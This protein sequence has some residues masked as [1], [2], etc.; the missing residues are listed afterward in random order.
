MTIQFTS[1][2]FNCQLGS[3][4]LLGNAACRRE[5]KESRTYVIL[6]R[7]GSPRCL[8]QE[9]QPQPQPEVLC[10]ALHLQLTNPQKR[11]QIHGCALASCWLPFP[12]AKRRKRLYIKKSFI[13]HGINYEGIEG[14][15]I[16]GQIVLRVLI[17]S[18]FPYSLFTRFYALKVHDVIPR[19]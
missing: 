15:S 5:V 11:Q 10:F 6:E 8:K 18:K 12:H 19:S 9:A 14:L 2:L 7:L 16:H 4:N 13:C 1:L 17:L 3:Q